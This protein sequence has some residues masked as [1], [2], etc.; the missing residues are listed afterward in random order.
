MWASRFPRA[1]RASVFICFLILVWVWVSPSGYTAP[2]KIVFT[3]PSHIRTTTSD[4]I[5]YA[6]YTDP[7]AALYIEGVRKPLSSLGSFAGLFPLS[8]GQNILHA[9]AELKG[10]VALAQLTITRKASPLPPPTDPWSINRA[11]CLPKRDIWFRAPGLLRVQCVGS[12]GGQATFSVGRHES[13]PMI[14]RAP[15]TYQGEIVVQAAD[16]WENEKVEFE[17]NSSDGRKK[18]RST[19]RGTVTV[20]GTGPPVV[21]ETVSEKPVPLYRTED[22]RTRYTDLPEG[23]RLEA[24]ARGERRYEVRLTEVRSAFVEVRDVRRLPDGTRRPESTVESITTQVKPDGTTVRIPLSQRLPFAVFELNDPPR[25]ELHI[26]GAKPDTWWVTRHHT[27]KTLRTIR[28]D[29]S[30][31]GAYRLLLGLHHDHWG[32]LAE[33]EEN[34]LC[35]E[36]NAPPKVPAIGQGRLSGLVVAI[37]PGHGGTNLGAR[38]P[39]GVYEK[40]IN[41][42]LARRLEQTLRSMGAE[43]V[44]LRQGDETVSLQERVN[45]ARRSGADILLSIHN[46]SIGNEN[47]PMATR[48]T[49]TYYYH[50]HSETLSRIL[51]DELREIPKVEPWGHI[52]EFDFTPIRSS[53]DMI[54]VLVECLFVSHP[55]DEEV[56]L[57]KAGEKEI[58]SAIARGLLRF[59]QRQSD[60]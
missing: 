15:G 44:L 8:V 41:R 13:I 29:L 52:G 38:A 25:L 54:G 46:N 50:P 10:K 24:V 48:G 17:L 32:Y 9:T 33:Y 58:V 31:E 37:D 2:L 26:Y 21:L 43:T 53:T 27:D 19:A 28:H 42:G 3:Y 57:S 59:M 49:S 60:R 23:V 36:V 51:Y 16:E 45:R 11:L 1:D 55:M 34:T 30:P 18:A 47:D 14:E 20:T 56:L 12:P 7:Q 35:L 39:T 6:G 5:R 4:R 40:T 22:G